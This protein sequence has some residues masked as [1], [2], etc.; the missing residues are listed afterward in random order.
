MKP[1]I[2]IVMK[3]LS[4]FECPDD[5]WIEDYV[6]DEFRNIVFSAECLAVGVLPPFRKPKYNRD[7]SDN[8]YRN[9]LSEDEKDDLNS[10][11][12]MCDGFILQGG[13]SGDYYELYIASYAIKHNIPVIGICAGFNILARAAGSSITSGNVLGITEKFHN[14]YNKEFRHGINIIHGTV[15]HEIFDTDSI[16]VNSLHTQFLDKRNLNNTMSKIEINA[17][18]TDILPTGLKCTTIE[19]FT[20][21]D[22]DFAMGVKWHPEIMEEEHKTKLFNRFL[23]V[24][25]KKKQ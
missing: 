13:L 11:L 3:P 25:K 8:I 19:A 5:I 4:D 16:F 9:N 10:I 24:C 1:V 7:E 20:I 23:E 17:T 21:R 14:V 6:K 2:G 22:V 18:V 12:E 15:L